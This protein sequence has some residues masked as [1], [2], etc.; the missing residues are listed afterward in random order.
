MSDSQH[1]PDHKIKFK[2]QF[3]K[4]RSIVSKEIS[5]ISVDFLTSETRKR[6]PLLK[7]D[8]RELSFK[9]IDGDSYILIDDEYLESDDFKTAA[10][11][12]ILIEWAPLMAHNYECSG[13]KSSPILGDLYVSLNSKIILC[14]GCELRLS[15]TSGPM[16]KFYNN[17]GFHGPMDISNLTLLDEPRILPSIL[18]SRSTE[19]L[20]ID[21]KPR[22]PENSAMEI[23]P[24]EK[25][26]EI[27]C[28]MP[29][30]ASPEH[31]EDVK[32][33]SN[34][35]NLNLMTSEYGVYESA[36]GASIPATLYW[37]REIGELCLLS[38]DMNL[39]IS[40]LESNLGKNYDD[41][42]KDCLKNKIEP[43]SFDDRTYSIL[44]HVVQ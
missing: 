6:F 14:A 37:R 11:P 35:P 44:D 31:V 29:D 15:S 39:L 5:L 33:E 8:P 25:N 30:T 18:H 17:V 20:P 41:Y 1:E 43:I 38:S 32:N 4:N 28:H 27:E 40:A 36:S 22:E 34:E 10:D 26:N 13:C 12:V 23:T 42:E 3:N 19:I 9:M 21:S 2:L 16:I 24:F 7:D